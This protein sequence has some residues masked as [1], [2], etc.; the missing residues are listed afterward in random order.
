[1][2]ID[3]ISRLGHI[4]VILTH[5]T[6]CGLHIK[7]S[8]FFDKPHD[9]R[10]SSCAAFSAT[11]WLS[12]FSFFLWTCMIAFE[13]RIICCVLL[14][15]AELTDMAVRWSQCY[16]LVGCQGYVATLKE[17]YGFIRCTDR[18][19]RMFFH[20]SELLDVEREL[21]QQQEVEFTV[22][23][24]P[25]CCLKPF[26]VH[27][28]HMVTAV[29]HPVPDLVK[30]PFVIFDIQALWCLAPDHQSARMSKITNDCLTWSGTGCS[31]AGPIWQQWVSKR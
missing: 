23:Q 24:V 18:D 27:C 13:C 2:G 26:D 4:P 17:G 21:K 19:A 20:Y 22:V 31:T 14:W 6:N 3:H 28:C 8:L 16:V 12:C 11:A 5:T 29:N 7:S 30:S 10:G 9:A 15:V 1:M 25:Q